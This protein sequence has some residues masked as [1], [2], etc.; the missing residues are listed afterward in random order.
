MERRENEIAAKEASVRKKE[1]EVDGL[2]EKGV[3]ELE[4]ISGFTSEEAKEYLL[5][6]VEDEVKIDTAKL[7]KELESRAKEEA[8]RKAKRVCGN[9]YSEMCCRSRIRE[10]HLRGTASE[11]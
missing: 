11:R 7:Y 2:H 8:G 3:Q 9:S 5:K 1:K 6:S 10:Y 4:R